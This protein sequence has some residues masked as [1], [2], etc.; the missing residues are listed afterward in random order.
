M[1]RF[2]K[3]FTAAALS[4]AFGQAHAAL[5]IGSHSFD[6]NAFAD[7]VAFFEPGEPNPESQFLNP[8]EALGA[9]DAVEGT[10]AGVALGSGGTLILEFTDNRLVG[11]GTSAADLVIFEGGSLE[12]SF[13]S[14]S[15]DGVTFFDVG[16]VPGGINELDIDAALAAEGLPA[17]TRI[18]FVRLIDDP[19][20]G[21][22]NSSSAGADIDAIGALNSVAIPIPAAAL[23]FAPLAAFFLRFRS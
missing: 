8:E 15:V 1:K 22:V 3:L 12:A 10:I 16:R 17:T 13:V 7:A 9:P 4:T 6:E 14:I 20:Q 23:L 21:S 19:D 18:A 2:I 5:V 11:D